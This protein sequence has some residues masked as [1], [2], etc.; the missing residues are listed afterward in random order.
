MQIKI[1]LRYHLLPVGIALVKKTT[2]KKNEDVEK[3]EPEYTVGE[4]VNWCSHHKKSLYRGFSKTN[5]RSSCC[6]AAETNPIRNHEVVGL[7]PGLT[8]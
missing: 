5:N 4:N 8:Q 2:N 7:I 6:G 3:R 1:T